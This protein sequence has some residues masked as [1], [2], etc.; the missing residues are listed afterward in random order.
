MRPD[1]QYLKSKNQASR[2]LNISIPTL[3]RLLKSGRGPTFI[4]V[5]NQ[6]RF[7]P[8]DLADYL[9]ANSHKGT[10]AV[11]DGCPSSEGR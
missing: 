6:V 9:N 4:K 3:D 5:G 10:A 8:E 11:L 1:P 7:R 2:Y